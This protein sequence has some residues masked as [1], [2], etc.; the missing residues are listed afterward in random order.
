MIGIQ[1][2]FAASFPEKMSLINRPPFSSKEKYRDYSV[3]SYSRIGPIERT[4]KCSGIECTSLYILRFETAGSAHRLT[5][6]VLSF[7]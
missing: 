2:R 5:S 6:S 3:Y 4:P 7:S 1:R